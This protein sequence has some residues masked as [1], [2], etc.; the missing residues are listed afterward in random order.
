M[1]EDKRLW[2]TFP[3]DFWMHPKFAPL[4]DSAIRTFVEMNGYSRIQD[5][6]GRIPIATA[7][8]F[9]KPKALGELQSNHP[10]RPTLTVDGDDFLI[11]DYAKHQQTKAA[12][13][14]AAEV[15][16]TNGRLGGR[17]PKE[18]PAITQGVSKTEPN[19]KQSQS[20]S[21]ENYMTDIGNPR[22]S[23]HLGDAPGRG[24]DIPESVL[25]KAKAAG[26]TNLPRLVDALTAAVGKPVSPLA[27]IELALAT[28]A[29]ANGNVR[30]VDKYVGSACRKSP[31]DIIWDYER[32][33]LGAIS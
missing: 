19:Q 25:A 30:N 28:T 3:I 32:L 11:R 18:N 10:K 24:L 20:Q 17:P 15:S 4:S 5:L 29:R 1:P 8:R 9:W 12:R 33:D 26:I 6:D 23:S 21:T 22:E 27:S 16:R 14:A 7:K 13:E 2:M 31:E